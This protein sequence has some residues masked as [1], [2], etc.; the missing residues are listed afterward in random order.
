MFYSLLG[1]QMHA[2][3]IY[4]FNIYLYILNRTN[5]F[6][7]KEVM[8]ASSILQG[9]SFP[10]LEKKFAFRKILHTFPFQD[11]TRIENRENQQETKKTHFTSGR[12]DAVAK[13]TCPL[14]EENVCFCL[15]CLTTFHSFFFSQIYSNIS[16]IYFPLK[17]SP[18]SIHNLRVCRDFCGRCDWS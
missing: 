14:Y 3:S 7:K 17:D 4:Y 15:G 2:Y 6:F 11:V 9:S 5:Y 16:Q 10:S 8:V 12:Y 1:M 13:W 18:Y